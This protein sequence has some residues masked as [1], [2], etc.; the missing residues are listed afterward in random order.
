M[1][2]EKEIIE[3]VEKAKKPGTF[4]IMDVLQERA[5]PTEEVEV[6]LDEEAAY[7]ASQ[8]DDQ[9]KEMQKKIDKSSDASKELK[10]LNAK[11]EE[12]V[13]K[14][15]ALVEEIGGSRFVFHLTGI[16]EGKREDLYELCLKKYPMKYETDRNPFTGQGEKKEINDPDR[17]KYFTNLVWQ[18]HIAKIVDPSGDIQ[19]GITYDE[20]V[21]LRRSLP[22][23][24][25]TY[26]NNA[27]EKLR[28]ATAVFLMSVNEDFL[29]K[30]SPGTTTDGSKPS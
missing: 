23:S 8:I 1:S 18:A 3:S 16:S 9:L 13:A 21:E 26:I 27:I 5:F 24:A 19:E 4:K 22:L 6:Y 10:E 28:T 14:K 7:L 25:T 12:I 30:S 15:D 11:Y 2:A 20:A 29:A 17:D